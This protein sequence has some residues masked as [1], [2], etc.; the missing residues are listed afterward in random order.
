MESMCTTRKVWM[1]RYGRALARMSLSRSRLKRE[2]GQ[3]GKEGGGS[4]S[5]GIRA[6]HCG[7]CQRGRLY[8][9]DG[10]EHYQHGHLRVRQRPMSACEGYERGCLDR[11]VA[12]KSGVSQHSSQIRHTCEYPTDMYSGYDV[13]YPSCAPSAQHSIGSDRYPRRHL[14]HRQQGDCRQFCISTWRDVRHT[15][16]HVHPFFRYET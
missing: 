12:S 15:H 5:H 9:I 1:P 16:I 13:R 14:L 6:F 7:N 3:G 11:G 10:V 8:G 4:Q 2:G